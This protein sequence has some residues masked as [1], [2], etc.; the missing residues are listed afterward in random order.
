MLSVVVAED[1]PLALDRLS[2]LVTQRD[3]MC[4]A[5]ACRNG[6]EA[7]ERINTLKPDIVIL[8]I[9]MPGYQGFDVL[10]YIQ[11]TPMPIV[12]FTTAY[13]QYAIKAFE[14]C[15]LD[16]I[17]KPYKDE[18]LNKSL[19]RAKE[20]VKNEGQQAYQEKLEAVQAIQKNGIFVDIPLQG[21]KVSLH[22]NDIF[23][24]SAQGNYVEL[25]TEEKNYLYRATVSAMEYELQEFEFIRV[26]R[27]L[28]LNARYIKSV[29]Y[30]HQ[31]NQ[32]K[33]IMMDQSEYLSGRSFK[34]RIAQWL[35]G[36]LTLLNV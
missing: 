19:E 5:A 22:S 9:Q 32:Y 29:L 36:H 35:D 31:N 4:L 33:F 25:Q 30:L 3:D 28:L 14:Y 20:C 6:I 15:A 26:H 2:R 23:S 13:E 34:Q 27:S 1:E 7:V 12:I 11:Q 21:T 24:I 16:Y 17:L 10:N 8:D 18:R